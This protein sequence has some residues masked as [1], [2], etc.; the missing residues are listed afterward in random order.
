MSLMKGN[1]HTK[2][3]QESTTD[4]KCIRIKIP[5]QVQNTL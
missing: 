3:T 5:E 4:R 1:N 2:N